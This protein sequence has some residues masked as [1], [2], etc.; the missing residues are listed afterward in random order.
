VGF[1]MF[2]SF[3]L[4]PQFVQ[5]PA[6][7]GYGFHANV[8]E[9]GFFLL[10]STVVMLVAGPLSGLL[11]TRL[12]SRVPLLMGTAIAAVAFLFLAIAHDE[13]WHI[14]LGT[15]L[16]G[17]GIGLAFAAMANL[18]VEAVEPTETGVATGM[19]TIM[20]SIGGSLGAQVA[21]SIVAGSIAA[22]TNLPTETGYVEAF[23]MSAVGLALA[24]A[25][26]L[27]IPRRL[28]P[29]PEPVASRRPAAAA[30]S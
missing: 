13:R 22:G 26:A 23:A 8:T 2:G 5:A 12:G 28:R 25:A 1:G 24:F 7:G 21:A 16:M 18:I 11:G 27:A 19:N 4:V 3:I 15:A 17:A 9:A 30:A 20:R 14:Y 10:P 29:R 6:A